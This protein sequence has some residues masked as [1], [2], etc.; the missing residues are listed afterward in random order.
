MKNRPN[1]PESAE[2]PENHRKG[3][4]LYEFFKLDFLRLFQENDHHFY[5]LNEEFS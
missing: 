5:R 1:S 3:T 4:S 2:F